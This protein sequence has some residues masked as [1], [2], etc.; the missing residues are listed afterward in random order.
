MMRAVR[1]H[2]T[3]TWALLYIERWLKA[4]V[5]MDDGTVIARERG[6]PQ[7]G[8]ISPLLANLFLHYA[9]DRW[10]RR[11]FPGIPFERYADDVICHCGTENQAKH[12]K[13][14]IERRFAE[15]GLTLHPQKTQIVY[16]KDARRK[17]EYPILKFDFLGYSFQP[18]RVKSG[19]GKYFIGFCPAISQKAPD[20]AGLETP[21]P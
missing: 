12:L 5:Q 8:V 4:P 20:D 2:T 15:C 6:T 9:F 13:D 1:K 10:M 18:R 11:E 19:T 14:A 7:G 21:S 16:C 3:C 17:G